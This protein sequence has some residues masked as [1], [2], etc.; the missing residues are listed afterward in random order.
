MTIDSGLKL[1]VAE[2][3]R[4]HGLANIIALV[5]IE[6]S[7]RERTSTNTA[8][9]QHLNQLVRALENPL[10]LATFAET[11]GAQSA[12]LDQSNLLPSEGVSNRICPTTLSRGHATEH[13]LLP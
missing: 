5:A 8:Q 10:V 3:C 9:R 1:Q 13:R 11:G 6:A 2:L 12:L 4:H 7:D